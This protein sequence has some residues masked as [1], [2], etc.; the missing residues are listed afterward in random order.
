MMKQSTTLSIDQRAQSKNDQENIS[1]FLNIF[2][3]ITLFLRSTSILFVYLLYS[4]VYIL[5]N[6]NNVL[7]INNFLAL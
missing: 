5:G 6:M 4:F 7:L 1:L 2:Y 3:I